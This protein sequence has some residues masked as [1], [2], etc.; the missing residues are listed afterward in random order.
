MATDTTAAPTIA[1]LAAPRLH[2]AA[3]LAAR[4][5]H[6]PAAAVHLAGALHTA[7]ELSDAARDALAG[8]CARA[9]E[10]GQA[11]AVDHVE[12]VA[13]GI[14]AFIAAPLAG[15]GC[16]AAAD[17]RTR[18]WTDGDR[19]ALYDAASLL[20]SAGDDTP[21]PASPR[22]G[23][24]VF[25][26]MFEGSAFGLAV[27][28]LGGRILRGN[29][30]LSQMLEVR[31][32]RLFGRPLASFLRGDE[33]AVG[34]V[35]DA[36]AQARDADVHEGLR[37]RGRGGR[38]TW[39]RVKLTIRCSQGR[40]VFA[41]ALIEDVG[42]RRRAAEAL[43]RRAAVVELMQRVS[44]AANRA[45][46]L[47][48]VLREALDLTCD[49]TGWP[50]GHVFV[51]GLEG[52]MVSS[53]IWRLADPERYEAL[54][55][56]T[57]SLHLGG[58]DGLPGEVASGGGPVWIEDV[59]REPGFARA[60]A[61]TRAGVRGAVAWPIR[62]GGQVVAVAEFFSGRPER[63]DPELMELLGNLGTQLGLV[64]EREQILEQ[65]REGER[66]LFQIL[67]ALPTAVVV[68]DGEGGVYY[69][70]RAARELVGRDPDH[71]LQAGTR[72]P[73]YA[74][75]VAGTEEPYPP[76]RLPLTRA[77]RGEAAWVDDLELRPPG[78]RVPLRVGAAPVLGAGG[79]VEYVVGSFVDLSERV[80]META[81]R[82]HARE[83]ERS[84]RELEEFAYVASH[85]LQEPL[86]KIRAFGDRLRERLGDAADPEARDYLARMRAAAGRMQELIHDL[87]QYSRVGRARAHPEPVELSQLL[88]EVL[89]DLEP[90][91]R[92]SGGRVEAGPL[93][94]VRADP[95]H[96]RQ[97]LQNL[98]ANG[99]KFHRPGAAPRVTVRAVDQ[100]GGRTVRLEVEDEGIGF[101]PE[102][103]ERI[104]LPFQRLH[105]RAEYE[106]TG[107]G[108]AI[109]RRIAEAAGGSIRAEGRP[110]RGATF[111]VTLPGCAGRAEDAP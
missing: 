10:S 106:G 39:V 14:A 80:A 63:P 7:G 47:H 86:R 69:A 19:A 66:R 61:A 60:Q 55:Q 99:L 18:T 88:D 98:V 79:R 3:R 109:C 43:A 5:L 44:A 33:G 6:A 111:T 16:I 12:G 94:T 27:L 20:A 62:A 31:A 54:R 22:Q 92:E 75:Y 100:D 104:F 37:L 59:Q 93:A 67:E 26:A 85:D 51:R 48:G 71:R 91:L 34:A 53:G 84:N 70:N 23:I 15:G 46:S 35:V 56:A 9:A 82:V 32:A 36:L 58:G 49:Y 95:V 50:V 107:M 25:R 11:L 57:E 30:A 65:L 89:A 29:R 42:D 105:G 24:G 40:P 76:D 68:R 83:L 4:A 8:L 21:P 72:M 74:L 45:R 1:T 96:V 108:L 17:V 110:G 41:L 52:E 97:L 103:A 13:G 38:E 101:E 90:R 102:H 73:T 81:L 78:R 28:D 77:L 2:A 64:V 87:L